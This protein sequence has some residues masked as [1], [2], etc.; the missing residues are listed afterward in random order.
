MKSHHEDYPA[1]SIEAVI[2]QAADQISGARPGARKDTLDNYLKRLG[3][4]ETIATSFAGVD[5]AYAIQ[6]GR[7]VR[8]FVN[9]QQVDDLG[10]HKMAREI[11]KRVQEELRYPGEIKVTVI[12]ENRVTEYA[13]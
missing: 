10:S 5:K 4:L 3:E 7:E 12:R 13:K 2:V 8:I 11:A 6:A 1:E 9:P